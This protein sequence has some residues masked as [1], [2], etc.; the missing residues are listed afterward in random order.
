MGIEKVGV[1]GC[2]LMGGGIAEAAIGGC[3]SRAWRRGGTSRGDAARLRASVGPLQLLDFIGVD[4]TYH[5]AE[6]LFGELKDLHCAPP[7]LLKQMTIAGLHG[8]KSGRG[9]YEYDAK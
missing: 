9:F 2:G 8:R 3:S 4:T 6:I 5:I 1:V 7:C